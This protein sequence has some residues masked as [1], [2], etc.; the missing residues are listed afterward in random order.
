MISKGIFF[1]EIEC[2]VQDKN[3]PR[4]VVRDIVNRR[5]NRLT[6]PLSPHKNS[7]HFS[8]SPSI[9][10]ALPHME[11]LYSLRHLGELKLRFWKLK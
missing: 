8:S 5:G 1:A 4:C 9:E 10:T 11:I 7:G 2:Y 3:V 6:V